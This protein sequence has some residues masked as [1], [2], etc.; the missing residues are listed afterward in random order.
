M[1]YGE[2]A[3]SGF[4]MEAKPPF[5][6]RK[7]CFYWLREQYPQPAPEH[8]PATVGFF[9]EG[10]PLFGRVVQSTPTLGF[11]LSSDPLGSSR[12]MGSPCGR[13]LSSS[14]WLKAIHRLMLGT[15]LRASLGE[16]QKSRCDWRYRPSWLCPSLIPFLTGAPGASA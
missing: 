13:F 3:S 7:P 16:V 5:C 4:G 6:L 8:L 12:L 10:E 1:S 15:K 2:T 9:S 11:T 14:A